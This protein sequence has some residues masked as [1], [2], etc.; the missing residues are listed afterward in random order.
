MLLNN[1]KK[2]LSIDPN[3]KEARTNYETLKNLGKFQ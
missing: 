2:A 3:S 1:T